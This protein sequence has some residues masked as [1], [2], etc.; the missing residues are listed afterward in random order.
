MKTLF[1]FL[2]LFSILAGQSVARETWGAA[3]FNTQRHDFGSVARGADAE[4]QF[5]LTNIYTSDVRLVSVHTSCSCIQ[6]RFTPQTL[7]PGETS[8][9]VIRLNT[10]GQFLRNAS[11]VLTVQLETIVSGARRMDTVQLFAS[12]FI[13]PDVVLT[14]GSIEFG[15]VIEGTTVERTLLLEYTGNPNWALMRME[16]SQPFIHAVAEEVRRDRGNIAYRITV[17][18]RDDAPVGYIRDALRFATNETSPGRANPVE[19]VL[20]V[21]GVVT[22]PIQIK[23]MPMLIGILTPGESVTKSIVVRS[24]TPIRITN[25][26]TTDTRFRFAF[27]EQASTVHIISVAFSA[28]QPQDIAEVIRISTNDPRQQHITVDAFVRVM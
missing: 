19:I 12:G 18:L 25:V 9:V 24:V 14:P 5:E 6:T 2:F 23:P 13:R 11:A 7:R 26:T 16:R 17:T 22:A 20:P 28:G 3:M 10:S 8:A 1:L 4:F 15:A 27:S 21:Q